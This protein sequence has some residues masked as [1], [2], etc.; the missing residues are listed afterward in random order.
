MTLILDDYPEEVGLRVMYKGGGVV[1]SD[2]KGSFSNNGIFTETVNLQPGDY[3]FK[4]SDSYGDGICC[5]YGQGRFEVHALLSDQ[6]QLLAESDGRF[7][8]SISVGF[9]VPSPQTNQSKGGCQDQSGTFLV[10]SEVKDAGCEWLGVNLGRYSYLCQFLD[11]AA[12]CPDTCD[13]C[14]FF[15]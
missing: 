4:L 14:E 9:S 1:V 12:T 13:A 3:R 7:T 5:G 8:N 10:D 11:V 6:D 15:K 2:P